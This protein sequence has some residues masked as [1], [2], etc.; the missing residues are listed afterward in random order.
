MKKR[1]M[2][3]ILILAMVLS[4]GSGLVKEKKAEAMGTDSWKF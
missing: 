2:A 4:M 1:A 3:V